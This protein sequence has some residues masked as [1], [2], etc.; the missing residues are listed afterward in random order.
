MDKYNAA[1]PYNGLLLGNK[2]MNKL[3]IYAT[4]W[5]NLKILL[6]EEMKTDEK[7]VHIVWFHSYKILENENE[8]I[9]TAD[10]WLPREGVGQGVEGGR[11]KLQRRRKLLGA[12]IL[13]VVMISQVYSYVKAYQICSFSTCA[14]SLYANYIS[15]KL[16]EKDPRRKEWE[17]RGNGEQRNWQ[18]LWWI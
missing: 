13:I 15:V 1:C 3:F 16:L 7:W 11:E 18:M 4:T 10:Q 12:I 5:L 17:E 2:R 9:V 14:V 6:S 8:F